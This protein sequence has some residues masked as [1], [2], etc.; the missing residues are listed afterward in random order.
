MGF[1]DLLRRLLGGGAAPAPR[2]TTP[3]PAPGTGHAQWAG[4]SATDDAISLR[5]SPLQ[6]PT[7]PGQG[8]PRILLPADAARRTNE[9]RLHEFA[10]PIARTP[11]ELAACMERST[12]ELFWLADPQR[13]VARGTGHYQPIVRQKRAGRVRIILAPRQHLKAVQ[14][15]ILRHILDRVDPHGAAHGFRRGRS[16]R[17]HARGH[18]RKAV[19]V[20]C[21]LENWF[22]QFTYARVRTLFQRLGYGRPV[23]RL[24]ALLCTAPVH[25]MTPGIVAATGLSTDAV[26]T[27]TRQSAA[28][29]GTRYA[30]LPQGA[31]TSP[32]LANLLSRPLDVRLSGLA[33]QYGARYTRYADDCAFSGGGRLSAETAR[34]IRAMQA[35]LLAER[36]APAPGKLWIRRSGAQQLVTGLIVNDGPNVPRHT[37]RRLRAILH[38]CAKHGL[39]YANLEDGYQRWRY[40][41][42][43]SWAEYLER[44]GNISGTGRWVKEIIVDIM[45]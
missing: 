11:A 19:L 24:L 6:Q 27:A 28:A 5:P 43:L 32:T 45:A 14:R 29:G 18:V 22:H 26:V 23:A 36:V 17:S 41:L 30:L 15:W 9:A 10:L 37:V 34:F 7:I 40:A 21:D 13:T 8:G 1:F 42:G 4:P 20:Q 35:I 2:P 33:K 16:I 25:E 3:A 39:A 38:N 12:R 31:P 44:V